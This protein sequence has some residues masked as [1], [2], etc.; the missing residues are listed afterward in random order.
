VSVQSVT[1]RQ[2]PGRISEL[3][4]WIVDETVGRP[5]AILTQRRPLG[6]DRTPNPLL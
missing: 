6:T 4:D 1:H 5:Q 2:P 3:N